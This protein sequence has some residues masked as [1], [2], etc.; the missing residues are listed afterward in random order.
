M[1]RH[2]SPFG[3]RTQRHFIIIVQSNGS[4][5]SSADPMGLTYKDEYFLFSTNQGGFHYSKNLSDWEFAPASFQRRPTDDDMCAPAAFVSGD[6]LF[7]TG[8]TYEGLPVWYSTSPKSGRFKRAIER[9]TLPSWDPC[10]FLD[11]DGK[12]YLYYGSI[13][14]LKRPD[15]GDVLYHTG[16]PS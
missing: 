9:N 12:L 11:D 15:L 7:Y 1:L 13:A 4:F 8:S 16:N 5:R 3:K 14:R 6:T 10:L 2:I